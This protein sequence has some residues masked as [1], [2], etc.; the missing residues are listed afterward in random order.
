MYRLVLLMKHSKKVKRLVGKHSSEPYNP[1]IANAF[2]R[3]GQIE[4]WNRGVER[5]M[6][7]CIAAGTPP[8]E[9]EAQTTGLWTVFHFLPE[10]VFRWT[11]QETPVETPAP[12]EMTVKTPVKT[13][14]L[15]VDLLGA[16]LEM[17]LVEVAQT[18]DKSVSAVNRASAKLV[19][20]G[21][22]RHIGPKKGGL[23]EVLP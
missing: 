14:E 21:K 7:A 11:T 15:I 9:F 2:F 10:H 23:W 5:M 17:T 18:I 22:L 4:S 6:E 16:N 8:P 20:Q 19:K 3:A 12:V 1:D 13:L